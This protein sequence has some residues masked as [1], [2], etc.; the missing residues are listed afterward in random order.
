MTERTE[1]VSFRSPGMAWDLAGVLHL[2]ADF[3]EDGTYP[4]IVSVHP[5]GSCKEQ[6]AGNVYAKALAE[7]GNVVLVFDASFQ[8]ESGG[9]PRLVEDPA[10]RVEDIRVAIDHLVTLPFVDA[11]RIGGIGVC[12]GGGYVINATMTD[13]RIKAVTSITGV[14]FGRLSREAFSQ[15]DP[16]AA[17]EQ[18]AEQRTAEARGEDT[19]VD[20]YLPE[21]VEAGKKAGVDDI[22]MLEATD[23]YKTG[24]GQTSGGATSAAFSRRAAAVGWDAFFD[25]EQLLTRPL[26]VV[27]GDKPGGFGAYR[28]GQEIYGRAASEDKRLLVLP[29]TSHYDLYD[30]PEPTGKAI[31]AAAEFFGTHL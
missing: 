4:A 12:G 29:D 27:I 28:D 18:M 8:G 30:Q 3:D 26:L 14:N 6:T 17:L 7:A 24:R 13:R 20:D 2:P 16:I 22:D 21:S 15:Y 1:Q 10:Q 23:Y 11:D 5:I 31:E 9:Q 25:A 19:R